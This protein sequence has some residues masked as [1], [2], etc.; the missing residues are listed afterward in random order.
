M[1]IELFDRGMVSVT[2]VPD[3]VR[4]ARGLHLPQFFEAIGQR[5]S[6]GHVPTIEEADK[7]G[8]RFRE[9]R[10]SIGG[11]QYAIAELAVFN[12]GM[13]VAVRGPTDDAQIVVDDLAAWLKSE[14]HYRDPA[15]PP[16]VRYQSDIVVRLDGEL[17]SAMAALSPL[18]TL[19]Q[20]QGRTREG[21]QPSVE[22]YGFSLS[23]DVGGDEPLFAIERRIG[24]PWSSRLY[25]S[26]A[27]M[28]TT[29]HVE[30]LRLLDDLLAKTS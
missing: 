24:A 15:T 12:D 19:I 8:A 27:L 11:R 10:I 22:S 4:P 26:R 30:T 3:E 17:R 21:T 25:Y 9:C 14:F 20:S 13:R 16:F 2:L 23:A 18:M 5:Y 7:S 29:A 6:A 28:V 1:K